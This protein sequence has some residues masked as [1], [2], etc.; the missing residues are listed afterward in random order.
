MRGRYKKAFFSQKA[1]QRE[2]FTMRGCFLVR[3]RSEESALRCKVAVRGL[4]YF[5]R[6]AIRRER[7]MVRRRYK[8]SILHGRERVLFHSEGSLPEMTRRARATFARSRSIE[9]L[10]RGRYMYT[11]GDGW[12]FFR[13]LSWNYM[14]L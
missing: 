13:S 8:R 11:E 4:F 2:R 3:K 6:K 7:F 9:R 1:I 14:T 10:W 5:I 12:M